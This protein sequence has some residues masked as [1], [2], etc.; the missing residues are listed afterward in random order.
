M[1]FITG[2]PPSINLCNNKPCDTI[3][4]VVDR[5]T[6]YAVYIATI[7]RLISGGLADILSQYIFT[8]FGISSGIVSD[9]GSLFTSH[10]WAGLCKV[11]GTK[12]RL[13]TAFHP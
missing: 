2:L 8:M 4:V 13:S 3:L 10:F 1:D 6:K 9:R 11:L 5:F 7:L 12:R